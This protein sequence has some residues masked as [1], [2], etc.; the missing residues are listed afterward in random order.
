MARRLNQVIATEMDAKDQFAKALNEAAANLSNMPL[1]TG[2]V[3]DYQRK[4]DEGDEQPSREAHPHWSAKTILEGMESSMT[5][6]FDLVAAKDWADTKARGSVVVDGTPIIENAPVS[7]LLWLERQ[8]T[9][10]LK[11]FGKIPTYDAT[12]RWTLDDK[13]GYYRSAP[14][15]TV[16]TKK[17]RK[18]LTLAKATKEHAEQAIPIDEDVQV[19]TWTTVHETGTM[20][21]AEKR[22]FIE[23]TEKLIAEVKHAREEANLTETEDHK[24][25]DAVY[26]YLLG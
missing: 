21:P 13:V 23:R 7:H 19:G 5:R 17:I 10:L 15:E 4:N 2:E 3:R 1:L 26:K 6:Y 22:G 16:S 18:A 8:L 9:E 20:S 12:K 25:G 24:V 14:V 11:L